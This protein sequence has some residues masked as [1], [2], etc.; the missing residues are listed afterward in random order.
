MA[1]KQ[2]PFLRGVIALPE[3]WGERFHEDPIRETGALVFVGSQAVDLYNG[4][5]DASVAFRGHAFEADYLLTV[6]EI[7]PLYELND[8]QKKVLAQFP[9]GVKSPAALGLLYESKP[10]IAARA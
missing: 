10:F 7:A 2:G 8:Y 9:Q 1:Y 3:N 6:K 4:K 5:L